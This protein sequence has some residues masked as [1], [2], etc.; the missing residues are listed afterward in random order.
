M[1]KFM[2]SRQVPLDLDESKN[3]NEELND[4]FVDAKEAGLLLR[5]LREKRG[6]TLNELCQKTGLGEDQLL[7]MENGF[8]PISENIAKRFSE[9]FHIPKHHFQ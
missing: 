6:W 2:R 7:G 8:L 4:F 1:S 3:I 9:I 5:E